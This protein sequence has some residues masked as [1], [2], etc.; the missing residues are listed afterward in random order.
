MPL[1]SAGKPEEE[2]YY[3][4]KTK[5]VYITP[6]PLLLSDMEESVVKMVIKSVNR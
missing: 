4:K 3:L 1:A 5:H 6:L 2:N